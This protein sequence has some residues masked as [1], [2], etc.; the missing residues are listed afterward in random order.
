[1]VAIFTHCWIVPL[2]YRDAIYS[3]TCCL[4]LLYYTVRVCLQARISVTFTG[5]LQKYLQMRIKALKPAWPIH[6]LWRGWKLKP[7]YQTCV[8]SVLLLE[9]VSSFRWKEKSQGWWWFAFL[10]HQM[11]HRLRDAKVDAQTSRIGCWNAS[12]HLFI[13]SQWKLVVGY[14]VMCGLMISIDNNWRVYL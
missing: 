12:C 5:S 4:L 2:I 10:L 9:T 1:M 8:M 11:I 13:M 7:K 6:R 3:A 14:D